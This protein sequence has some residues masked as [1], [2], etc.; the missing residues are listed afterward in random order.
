[1]LVQIIQI[2]QA[3]RMPGIR[4]SNTLRALSALCSARLLDN[5]EAD[6]LAS[7]YCLL[8]R[9]RNALWLQTGAGQDVLPADPWR[10]RAL[11][12][13]FG[14]RDGLHASAEERLWDDIHAQMREVRLL[15]EQRFM[16]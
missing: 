14:Y 7:A 12:L 16:T 5:T 8:T 10:R 1:W 3:P 11:A 4:I 13:R 6:T 15:F 2:Q 9:L